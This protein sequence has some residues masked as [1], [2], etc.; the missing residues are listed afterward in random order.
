MQEVYLDVETRDGFQHPH[1]ADL[2]ESER[3]KNIRFG[4]AVTSLNHQYQVW[5]HNDPTHSPAALWSYLNEADRVIGWNIKSFDLP[6]IL[7]A[8]D[9]EPGD[10][11][12]FEVFDIFDRIRALTGR[13]YKLGVVLMATLGIE[14]SE[15]GAIVC[16]MLNSGSETDMAAVTDY[17]M[18]D[19][20]ALMLLHNH[21]KQGKALI[22]P[23]RPER[24]AERGR[25][26]YAFYLD[27]DPRFTLV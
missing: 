13:W 23:E 14:K 2:P 12:P 18:K 26:D 10:T 1:I 21:L 11:Y 19:V 20:D 3:I 6:V 17:C 9:R 15:P 25:G 24:K 4:L 22:L 8:L 7:Y 27:P 16:D 5:K